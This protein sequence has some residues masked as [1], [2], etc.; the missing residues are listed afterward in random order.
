MLGVQYLEIPRVRGNHGE[1]RGEGRKRLREKVHVQKSF[2]AVGAWW[3]ANFWIFQPTPFGPPRRDLAME[4]GHES[5]TEDR[6]ED[7]EHNENTNGVVTT[8]Q[9]LLRG[10]V[11]DLHQRP[12]RL[13]VLRATC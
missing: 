10:V 13:H 1:T 9:V 11:G 4:T 5:E 6:R 7:S 2:C 12:R 8:N 3:A